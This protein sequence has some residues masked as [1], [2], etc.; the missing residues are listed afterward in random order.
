MKPESPVR[1]AYLA[2]TKRLQIGEDFE[3]GKDKRQGT[4]KMADITLVQ[5]IL[6]V[7]LK[8]ASYEI[9]WISLAIVTKVP[10]R[11]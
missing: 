7:G 5:P 10:L 11:N 9:K 2:K 4:S 6:M 3:K 1:T 8:S